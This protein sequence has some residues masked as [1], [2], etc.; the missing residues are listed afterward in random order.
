MD[1]TRTKH[2]YRIIGGFTG[3]ERTTCAR[4][5]HV[6]VHSTSAIEEPVAGCSKDLSSTASDSFSAGA[7]AF[8]D[9]HDYDTESEEERDQERTVVRLLGRLKSE[10]AA[11]IH[12]HSKTTKD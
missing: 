11:D 10:S 4:A 8:S 2:K 1:S 12:V 9:G 3:K 7:N 6:C 5:V